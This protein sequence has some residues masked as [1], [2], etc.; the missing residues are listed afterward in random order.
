MTSPAPTLELRGAQRRW[1]ERLALGP[2]DLRIAPG[3]RV[4]LAG[5]SGGGK[6][7]LLRLLAAAL[8]ASGGSVAI[9]GRSVAAMR[10]HQIRDHRRRCALIDQGATLIPEVSVH[11]NVLA[12]RAPA[13]P[14]WRVL[15]SAL[16]PLE[17][18]A[19]AALLGQV[20]LRERQWDR[21]GALS[22]G[23]R[24]RVAIAR[25]LASEPSV[26]LADEPTAALDPTTAAEVIALLSRETRR[27]ELT[28]IVSTHRLSQ[29]LGEVDRVIGLREGRVSLD[30]PADQIDDATLAALYAGSRERS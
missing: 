27:R 6:T 16:W 4:A 1:G 25:A 7:T 8:R 19:V 24:Q 18:E 15:A 21:V 17:R 30:A 3:E 11:D 5:P 20:D 9:D 12:G 13:W 2:V 14:W 26:L 23:Q 29:V 28:L 10:P 22:G